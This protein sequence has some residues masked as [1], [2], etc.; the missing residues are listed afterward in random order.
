[1][2]NLASLQAARGQIIDQLSTTTALIQQDRQQ[3]A[4]Q[5]SNL[6]FATT[7]QQRTAIQGNISTLK[8]QIATNVQKEAQLAQEL[9]DIDQQIAVAQVQQGPRTS[10]G[11]TVAQAQRANDDGADTVSPQE[12]PAVTATAGETNADRFPE[13]PPADAGTD[14]PV[15]TGTNSQSLPPRTARP[16]AVR[17]TIIPPNSPG[18]TIDP[19]DADTELW[20][21]QSP[22]STAVNDN[23][24]NSNPTRAALNRLFA[25]KITPQ[26]NVLD[27][28]ASYTYAI[29]IYLMSPKDYQALLTNPNALPPGA[30]LI[31]QSG[32]APP[33]G[34]T[35]PTFS[36]V[37]DSEGQA[38]GFYGDPAPLALPELGRN[39]NF[40]LDY[41]LDDVRI[42]SFINGK[43]VGL[44][45]NVMRIQFKVSEPNGIT[46]IDNLYKAV[47]QYVRLSGTPQVNY[48][49]Q[50]YLMA[51]RFYGYDTDGNLVLSQNQPFTD[52][53]TNKRIETVVE[54]Y[55]PFQFT[56]IKFRVANKLVE[57]DCEAVAVQNAVATAPA[58]GTIP[59]NVELTSQS[60]KDLLQGQQA[61]GQTG[62]SSSGSQSQGRVVQTPANRIDFTETPASSGLPGSS[63]D[64]EFGGSGTGDGLA[65]ALGQTPQTRSV[66]AGSGSTQNNAPPKA[67]TLPSKT[68]VTGLV[69]ALNSAQDEWVKKGTYLYPDRY[70]IE[71]DPILAEA[72]VV[73]PGS[74]NLRMTPMAPNENAR[75]KLLQRTQ[76]VDSNAKKFSILAGTSIVQFLDQ[77]TRNS[78]YIYD[79]QIRRYDPKTNELEQ[80]GKPANV[81]GWY[82]ISMQAVPQGADRYDTKRNDYAYDITYR[83]EVYGINDSK[84]DFFPTAQYRGTHKRYDYW[85]TGQNTQILDYQQDFNYLYYVVQN[86][87]SPER[88]RLTTNWREV[89]RYVAQPRS[90]QSDQMNEGSV[91]EPSA[92]LADYLYSPGDTARIKLRILGDPAWIQQG[93]VRAGLPRGSQLYDA[94]LPD[95][96]INYAG[97]QILF[98]VLW[99]KPQDYDLSE[100]IM[101]AGVNNYGSNRM[102]GRAGDAVQSHVYQAV[103]CTSNFTKGRFEQELEGVQVFY[104]LPQTQAQS[105]RTGTRS[106]TA[107]ASRVVDTG[108]ETQRL[109]ARRGPAWAQPTSVTGTQPTSS[110]A[111]G[112]QQ[113]LAARPA[114]PATSTTQTVGIP[115]ETAAET[116]RLL[117]TARGTAVGAPSATLYLDN[118]QTVQVT[119]LQEIQN[120]TGSSSA[121]AR[122]AAAN[123]L[124][125]AQQAAN[126]PN[127]AVRPQLIA[128]DN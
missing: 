127:T 65:R 23:S 15:V 55:I 60:L 102:Q 39:P 17:Q 36:S 44:A 78:T 25:G 88:L 72:K 64:V 22:G 122:S 3:L 45:H 21:T 62:T 76:A 114:A 46:F 77:V 83:V 49:A 128:K 24:A 38:G 31:L 54:K 47:D 50:T 94:F 85:F 13:D 34:G 81:T 11:E 118:N 63:L 121:Q 30:N 26:S 12:P 113:S 93:D 51:I 104:S 27:Q 84:S 4:R 99:N 14:A 87:L 8:S 111:R 61:F 52:P 95:G 67:S 126:S 79:Q 89:Q 123:R 2:A 103:L 106:N 7:P 80:V 18:Q 40:P 105:S 107:P 119:S 10:S 59:Y 42:S 53:I 66:T 41:Y 124:N 92:Q 82:R 5:E 86:S 112:I 125:L 9:K 33:A 69:D 20:P 16:G 91:S 1:M 110:V 75:D 108:D 29:S 56:S 68:L 35:L 19:R 71:L 6:Q 37:T 98:E 57:Y 101:D 58:R 28:Y 70:F 73:P 100:G 32:G 120:Y 109:L 43:G 48:A 117:G 97:Q 115:N 96:T 116:N 74:T 90:D